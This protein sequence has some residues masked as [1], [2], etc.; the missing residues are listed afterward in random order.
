L[1]FLSNSLVAIDAGDKSPPGESKGY[2][3]NRRH[4]PVSTLS[5]LFAT[6][7]AY[8]PLALRLVLGTM[9]LGHGMQKL[10]GAFGGYGFAGTMGYFRS[11]GIPSVLGLA[12]ILTEF[13]GG[14]ALLAG[15]GTRVSALLVGVT[16][17]VAALRVHLPNGFFMNWSGK[18][19]G[20]GL[21][22]FLLGVGISV[23]LVLA[24]GGAFSVDRA[25]AGRE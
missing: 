16:L 14:L 22:F 11:L 1:F 19:P 18:Q 21:E 4:S 24:G 12:A 23:A 8:A 9:I 17:A 3:P 7:N 20:E 25:L 6:E 10:F 15:A 2:T 13:F 5:R